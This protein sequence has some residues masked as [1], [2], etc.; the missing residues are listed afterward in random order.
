MTKNW[1][2]FRFLHIC[3]VEKCEISP[4][5]AKFHISPHLLC[6]KTEIPLHVEKFHVLKSE[7]S[8]H[9]RFFLHLHVG[10][11]GDKY[12]VCFS[13]PSPLDSSCRVS[14]PVFWHKEILQELPLLPPDHDGRGRQVCII[15]ES[16]SHQIAGQGHLLPE[17]VSIVCPPPPILQ[18]PVEGLQQFNVEPQTKRMDVNQT[19]SF[20]GGATKNPRL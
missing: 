6:G 5:L 17:K 8:P 1:I 3:P 16:S 10:D 14:S 19:V 20:P 15:V 11:R 9:G 18:T 13:P 2:N 4:N 12:Q 7:I